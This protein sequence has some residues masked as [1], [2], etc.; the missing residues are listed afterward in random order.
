MTVHI[1][2]MYCLD[3]P[4][5]KDKSYTTLKILKEFAAALSV[6]LEP[7]FGKTFSKHNLKIPWPG[8]APRDSSGFVIYAYRDAQKQ[9]IQYLNRK[10]VWE[11]LW[12]LSKLDLLRN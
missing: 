5:R 12:K 3:D 6:V 2:V 9:Y 7:F 1:L 4:L 11:L 8:R 10:V